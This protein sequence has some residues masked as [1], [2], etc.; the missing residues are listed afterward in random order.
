MELAALI[1]SFGVL[2]VSGVAAVA[3]VVQ[4]RAA[5]TSRMEA[6]DALSEA[7]SARD[8]SARLAAIATSAFI[9]QAEAQEKANA[10]KVEEMRPPVWTGPSHVNGDRWKL[11]NSSGRAIH[12]S[13]YEILPDGAENLIRLEGPEDGIYDYGDALN[14]I[15][16]NRMGMRVQ[17][18]TLTWRYAD[19]PDSPP[20][21]FIIPM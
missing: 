8:E 5:N 16:T 18:L 2:V 11:L 20:N 7:R 14:W 19:E 9:R 21:R 12:V 10:L 1:V 17:K 4:A 6:D 3:A 15:V 13:E